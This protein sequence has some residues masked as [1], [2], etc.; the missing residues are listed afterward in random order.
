M[1]NKEAILEK[2]R[3]TQKDMWHEITPRL[4]IHPTTKWFTTYTKSGFMYS[5]LDYTQITGLFSEKDTAIVVALVSLAESAVI[6]LGDFADIS[7]E[8]ISTFI[9]EIVD[10]MN[11]RLKHTEYII[12]YFETGK[13]Y[14]GEQNWGEAIF[15]MSQPDA[16]AQFELNETDFEGIQSGAGGL[17]TEDD[18][19]K[20]IQHSIIRKCKKIS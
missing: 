16:I 9:S 8:Y 15:P 12:E 14:Y 2:I 20:I 10:E 5:E 19:I 13:A 3:E 18:I 1:I 17:Y 6:G 4:H 7:R 11:I